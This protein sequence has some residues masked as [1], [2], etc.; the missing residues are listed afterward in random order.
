VSGMENCT[1]HHHACD[2]REQKFA[3][4]ENENRTL[5]CRLQYANGKLSEAML[6]LDELRELICDTEL[7]DNT[8]VSSKFPGKTERK[9]MGDSLDDLDFPSV[10]NAMFEP[11]TITRRRPKPPALGIVKRWRFVFHM[12]DGGQETVGDDYIATEPEAM[13]EGENRLFDHEHNGGETPAS[14]EVQS[15]GSPNA[16]NERRQEPPERKP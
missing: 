1:T 9:D 13:W 11:N 7:P 4:M 15:Q 16:G 12:E 3:E 6:K 14:I 8:E 2:C 5:R 10:A